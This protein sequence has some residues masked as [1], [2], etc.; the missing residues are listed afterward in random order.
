ML[1]SRLLYETQTKRE[2][3][4]EERLNGDA[5]VDGGAS[6]GPAAAADRC[7]RG[8]QEGQTTAVAAALWRDER[9]MDRFDLVGV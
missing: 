5:L 6:S 9:Q 2:I 3:N 7:H 1:L 8:V 4:D